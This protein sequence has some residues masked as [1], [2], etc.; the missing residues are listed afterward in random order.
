MEIL[1]RPLIAFFFRYLE[2][3]EIYLS[4]RSCYYYLLLWVLRTKVQKKRFIQY[5]RSVK[6]GK[7]YLILHFSFAAASGMATAAA[8]MGYFFSSTLYYLKSEEN[9]WSK[10]WIITTLKYGVESTL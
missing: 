2:Y 10:A 6:G 3:A 8:A 5:A 7:N 4:R 1:N 9:E